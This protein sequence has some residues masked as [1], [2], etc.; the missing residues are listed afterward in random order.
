MK[1]AYKFYPTIL[2][3][4]SI[5]PMAANAQGVGTTQLERIL[6]NVGGTLNIIIA[7]LFVLATVIFLWGLVQYVANSGDEAAAKKGRKLMMYGIVGLAV[8]ASVW[9]VVNIVI[10]YFL[11]GDIGKIPAKPGQF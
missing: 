2:A 1:Q 4:I 10:Q 3:L 7:F 11:N 6:S 5:V 9:G 8:M